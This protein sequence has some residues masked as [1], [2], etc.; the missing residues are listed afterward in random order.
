ML[1]L[2]TKDTGLDVRVVANPLAAV[3]LGAGRF[4]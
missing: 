3:A 2:R 1:R 4:L